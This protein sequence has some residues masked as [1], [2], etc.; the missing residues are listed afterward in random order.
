MPPPV[1]NASI[2]QRLPAETEAPRLLPSC[3]DGWKKRIHAWGRADQR[4]PLV[5]DGA[6]RGGRGSHR[7]LAAR[8]GERWPRKRA[9]FGSPASRLRPSPDALWP[10]RSALTLIP[11]SIRPGRPGGSPGEPRRDPARPQGGG[12]PARRPGRGSPQGAGR[13]APCRM[14]Q[15]LTVVS[16]LCD[17]YVR[18]PRVDRFSIRLRAYDGSQAPLFDIERT[19]A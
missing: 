7:Q 6:H 8:P 15:V 16:P 13:A 11:L 17:R 4:A 14:G 19:S 1:L 3:L 10:T 18:P 12:N 9:A 5:R 2:N